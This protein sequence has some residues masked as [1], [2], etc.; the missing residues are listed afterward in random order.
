[1][2]VSGAKSIAAGLRTRLKPSNPLNVG[3]SQQGLNGRWDRGVLRPLGAE[4]VSRKDYEGHKGCAPY[5]RARTKCR[6]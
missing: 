6:H 1:M 3:R 4:A 2:G 5:A